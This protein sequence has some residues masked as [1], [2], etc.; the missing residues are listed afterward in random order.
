[1]PG[2]GGK[3]RI[4]EQLQGGQKMVKKL[5]GSQYKKNLYIVKRKNKFWVSPGPVYVKLR[6]KDESDP[7]I[8]P[9]M[10]SKYKRFPPGLKEVHQQKDLGFHKLALNHDLNT[11]SHGYIKPIKKSKARIAKRAIRTPPH[12]YLGLGVHIADLERPSSVHLSKCDRF[13]NTMDKIKAST[14]GPGH[15]KR[16]KDTVQIHRPDRNSIPFCPPHK[17]RPKTSGI[18]SSRSKS[19]TTS[20]LQQRKN[21]NAELRRIRLRE[22]SYKGGGGGV[23][24]SSYFEPSMMF[25]FE[26]LH[27]GPG[28]YPNSAQAKLNLETHSSTS[29]KFDPLR[30]QKTTPIAILNDSK[31]KKVQSW[32][33]PVF[34]VSKRVNQDN[35]EDHFWASESIQNGRE[36]DEEEESDSDED[37]IEV[38]L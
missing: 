27:L 31:D 32:P 6:T 36:D 26:N 33:R 25:S 19:I 35:F 13:Y 12:T 18:I 2:E 20:I 21:R 8:N 7:P 17:I 34:A 24:F 29:V 37:E 30:T 5:L 16:P 3:Q 10:F 4:R 14:P 9:Q 22:N 11:K 28:C 15:Y 1:L 23:K 38:E